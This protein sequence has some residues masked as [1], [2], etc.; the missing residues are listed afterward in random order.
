VSLLLGTLREQLE[1]L[2]CAQQYSFRRFQ[3]ARVSSP[4][5]ALARLRACRA[6]LNLEPPPNEASLQARAVWQA[7]R[8]DDSV[9]S[10]AVHI[11]GQQLLN[12]HGGNLIEIR[13]SEVTDDAELIWHGVRQRLLEGWSRRALVRRYA[14]RSQAFEADRLRLVADDDSSRAEASLTRDFARY[15]FDQGLN[16]L[17]DSNVARLRPD[18]LDIG[19]QTAFY[20]E[21]KQYRDSPRAMLVAAYRQVWSTWGRLREQHH[22]PEAFIAVFRRGGPRAELPA[23]MSMSGLVLY[24]VLV[25]IS[26]EAGS[27]ERFDPIQLTAEELLP[28][29][30]VT[31]NTP[32]A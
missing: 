26:L 20:V 11:P 14:A 3:A 16:P 1:E 4:G 13:A 10:A 25:D 30:D 28:R 9:F 23:R 6:H 24:S 22:C 5:R 29:T 2:N 32:I 7:R 8:S 15:L 19:G 18:V 17:L 12:R 27:S 21:A 31:S